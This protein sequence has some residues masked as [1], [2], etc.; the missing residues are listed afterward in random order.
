MNLK[1]RRLCCQK[2]HTVH[3]E[4]PDFIYPYKHY[5][6]NL[7]QKV[8]D[9][10]CDICPAENSTIVRWKQLKA[11][12]ICSFIILL[13][14]D[15]KLLSLFRNSLLFFT[16]KMFHLKTIVKM[17]VNNMHTWFAFFH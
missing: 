6:L 16:D 4:L 7:I 2:C 5:C 11:Q 12:I 17:L 1:L 14:L 3:T 9:N 10:H 13:K 8:L 15:I